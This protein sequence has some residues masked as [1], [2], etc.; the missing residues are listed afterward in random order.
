[1][2]RRALTALVRST[3]YK[4]TSRTQR[5]IL[6]YKST[7]SCRTHFCGELTAQHVNSQVGLL[8][9]NRHIVENARKNP[10]RTLFCLKRLFSVPGP[11]MRL[12]RFVK[13][14]QVY[15]AKGRRF[16]QSFAAYSPTRQKE[17]VAKIK[18][19]HPRVCT[20]CQVC[21]MFGL[22]HLQFDQKPSFLTFQ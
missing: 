14:G 6:R 12:D 9:L 17:L 11:S 13:D 4:G 10:E 18:H 5:C 21:S 7:F 20:R 15:F 1:M 22:F 2:F 19:P 16:K 8:T 3:P